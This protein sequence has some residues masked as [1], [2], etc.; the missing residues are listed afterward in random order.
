[1]LFAALNCSV[2]SNSLVQQ[3]PLSMESSRQ[4]YWSGLPFSPLAGLPNPS[5][6]PASPT[7]PELAGRFFNS[8]PPGKP[9]IWKG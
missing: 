6:E 5:I 8:E 3:A 4:V 9:Q 1:M 7:F 2:V